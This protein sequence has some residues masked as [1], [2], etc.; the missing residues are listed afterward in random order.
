MTKEDSNLTKS[1]KKLELDSCNSHSKRS[2]YKTSTKLQ[3][4]FLRRRHSKSLSSINFGRS[5]NCGQRLPL[6]TKCMTSLKHL[7]TSR[8]ILQEPILKYTHNCKQL[9]SSLGISLYS[10]ESHK[11]FKLFEQGASNE[12]YN[13]R[14]VIDACHQLNLTSSKFDVPDRFVSSNNSTRLF[15]SNNYKSPQLESNVNSGCS[16]Q[17]RIGISSQCDITIDEL[18]S[19][20]ETFVYIPKKM[21]SMAEMMYI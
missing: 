2:N 19:Y 4:P 6:R 9:H 7:Q 17:A 3:N 18:A 12:D 10:V 21:S 11:S 1:L 20:F 8:R 16:H 15:Q 13:F 14:S 5:C